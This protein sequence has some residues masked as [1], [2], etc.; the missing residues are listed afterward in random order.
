MSWKKFLSG[1]LIGA[2]VFGVSIGNVNRVNA[3][4][5]DKHQINVEQQKDN[6]QHSQMNDK[7][8]K[9]PEPPKDSNGNPLPPPDKD[10]QNFDGN[11]GNNP[12]ESPNGKKF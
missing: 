2:F 5:S 10:G 12:P 3:K 11:N 7:N 9:P 1:V 6:S 8:N 4:S